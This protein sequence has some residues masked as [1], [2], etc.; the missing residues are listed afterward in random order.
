MARW[1]DGKDKD[2]LDL[3]NR[4]VKLFADAQSE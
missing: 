1:Y 4:M 3:K 2:K